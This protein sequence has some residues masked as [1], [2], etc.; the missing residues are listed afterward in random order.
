MTDDPERR[1]APGDIVAFRLAEIEK[2]LDAQAREQAQGFTDVRNQISGLTFLRIDWLQVYEA[3]QRTA[4]QVHKE[5]AKDIH[6][7]DA[8]IAGKVSDISTQMKLLWTVV[9]A[10]VI[11]GLIG[12][13]F[14]YAG[15][16]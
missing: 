4:D 13:L 5:L 16:T 9:G 8:A 14:A 10:S 11:A 3:D 2:R 7:G 6:D 1:P 15:P 12:V